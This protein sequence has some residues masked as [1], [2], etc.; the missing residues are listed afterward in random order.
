MIANG[1]DDD[2]IWKV[3]VNHEEQYSVW[4]AN[5][6]SPLGWNEVGKEGTKAECLT[7][8]NEVWTDMRPLSLR[9]QM[10]DSQ[11]SV[12]GQDALSGKQGVEAV[13]EGKSDGSE[14][15][16]SLV[17]RLCQGIHPVSLWP[18]PMTAAAFSERLDNGLIHV[19]FPETR[20][21]TRIG[22][23]VDN[24]SSDISQADLEKATGKV[25]IVG[26]L[27]LDYVPV[28]CVVDIALPEFTGTGRLEKVSEI[29]K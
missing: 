8:I 22:V 23:R 19:E 1:T 5:R 3:V 20:G 27:V 17:N 14:N 2:R 21:G 15:H 24:N 11:R 26:H 6:E 16:E 9:K 10:D 28:R 29:P 25:R 12:E 7:Y 4:F 18:T 13:V